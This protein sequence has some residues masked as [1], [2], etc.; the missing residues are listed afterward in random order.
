M[1]LD[2]AYMP[3]SNTLN[4]TY[5][6]PENLLKYSKQYMSTKFVSANQLV[7]FSVLQNTVSSN[8]SLCE[9]RFCINNTKKFS[10]CTE[11]Q[12]AVWRNE[13]V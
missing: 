2:Y 9:N 7:S 13:R 6:F 4:R 12:R 3:N 5:I 8:W 1:V 11:L 10:D